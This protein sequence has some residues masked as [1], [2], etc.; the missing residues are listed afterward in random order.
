VNN[1]QKCIADFVLHSHH[2]IL[3]PSDIV[4]FIKPGP[5]HNQQIVRAVMVFQR[6]LGVSAAIILGSP[7]L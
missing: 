5:L 3:G 2:T 1:L 6:P 7:Q 4:T